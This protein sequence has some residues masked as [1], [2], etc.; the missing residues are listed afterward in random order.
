MSDNSTE[1]YN[2]I[3]HSLDTY[4]TWWSPYDLKD[5]SDRLLKS[6]SAP[7]CKFYHYRH[8]DRTNIMMDLMLCLHNNDYFEAFKQHYPSDYFSYEI[9]DYL[10]DAY[11]EA[12]KHPEV[13]TQIEKVF[14]FVQSNKNAPKDYALI[15][16]FTD[17]PRF[18]QRLQIESD[19]IGEQ[20]LRQSLW[21]QYGYVSWPIMLAWKASDYSCRCQSQMTA[22]HYSRLLE[23]YL[24]FTSPQDV[25]EKVIDLYQN[26][27]QSAHYWAQAVS[28]KSLA[29]YGLFAGIDELF[30]GTPMYEDPRLNDAAQKLAL[31]KAQYCDDTYQR[32][33]QLTP[34]QGQEVRKCNILPKK[35]I[36]AL[37]WSTA[38]ERRHDLQSDMGL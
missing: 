37:G 28:L 24:Q 19:R 2:L 16:A 11:I 32:L 4:S 26:C 17:H 7:Y 31:I 35:M 18:K 34:E 29:Q 22:E 27:G 30:M 25:M 33:R 12:S 20:E 9:Y 38:Q 6:N 13:M 5:L 10:Q 14:D 36:H 8:T 3:K 1:I 21:V 23:V 15:P